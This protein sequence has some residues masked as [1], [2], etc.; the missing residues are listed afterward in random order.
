M[1]IMVEV[2][3]KIITKQ[4]LILTF[5][6]ERSGPGGVSWGETRLSSMSPAFVLHKNTVDEVILIFHKG[7]IGRV[8]VKI[9]LGSRSFKS[10]N[11]RPNSFKLRA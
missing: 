7:L 4:A 5:K 11:P 9:N 1:F 2:V 6:G 3:I 10:V 8:S